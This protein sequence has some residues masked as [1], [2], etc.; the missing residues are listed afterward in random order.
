MYNQPHMT[1][2]FFIHQHH[3]FVCERNKREEN[4]SHSR[5]LDIPSG[6]SLKNWTRTNTFHFIS[7]HTKQLTIGKAPNIENILKQTVYMYIN[8]NLNTSAWMNQKCLSRK[9]NISFF[10]FKQGHSQFTN[11]LKTAIDKWTI[12]CRVLRWW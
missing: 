8:Q 10:N 12:E 3:N 5:N 11:E 2:Q 6:K 9:L 1:T 4:T 7:W